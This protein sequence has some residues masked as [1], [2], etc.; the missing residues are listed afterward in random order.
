[1]KFLALGFGGWTGPKTQYGSP[2]LPEDT[3][4]CSSVC[5]DLKNG[6]CERPQIQRQMSEESDVVDFRAGEAAPVIV[7]VPFLGSF[8]YQVRRDSSERN[9]FK[10]VAMPQPVHSHFQSLQMLLNVSD[11]DSS[12]FFEHVGGRGAIDSFSFLVPT[13]IPPWQRQSRLLAGRDNPRP[14]QLWLNYEVCLFVCLFVCIA[15]PGGFHSTARL[16]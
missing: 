5:R 7:N 16:P 1:M 8:E 15:T 6:T 2:P 13:F 14:T 10:T 11:T 12:A 4:H 9:H 3:S